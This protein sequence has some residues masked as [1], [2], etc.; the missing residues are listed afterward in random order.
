MKVYVP[1][2]SRASSSLFR[3][4]P[5]AYM[6]GERRAST[7]YVV[8]FGQGLA[9]TSG[10][11]AA[12]YREVAVMETPV[13]VRGIAAT[14]HHIGKLVDEEGESKFLMSDDDVKIYVRRSPDAFN[15]VYASPENTE[16][17]LLEVE[18]RLDTCG[19]VGVSAR[20][21]N[22]RVG[23]GGPDLVQENTRTLR[24]LAYQTEAFL[25]AEHGRVAVMEDFDVN[26]QLLEMGLPNRNLAYWAQGQIKTN[27]PGGCS[28]YRTHEVHEASARRLAELHPGFVSLRQKVNKT[29]TDGFGTR[30][31]VTI[32][33]RRAY[34][35]GVAR[36]IAA[37][38][39]VR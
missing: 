1:S 2:S 9:Y 25:A 21:G 26:L 34:M 8:P 38:E 28:V 37:A 39:A 10:L 23:V 22:N 29:D 33:W 5:L 4:G 14:R 17:M 31:E 32:Q 18:R 11:A 16:E 24:M 19:H 20:E 35:S 7:T 36:T 6:S 3:A 27:A 15:L 13:D 30:T 12:G